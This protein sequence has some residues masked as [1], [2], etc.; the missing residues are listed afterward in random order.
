[1]KGL[2][3]AETKQDCSLASKWMEAGIGSK[4][5]AAMFAGPLFL[6]ANMVASRENV[7]TD[8]VR[9]KR[10]EWQML[11]VSAPVQIIDNMLIFELLT[12]AAYDGAS[13]AQDEFDTLATLWKQETEHLSS[14]NMIASHM[15]YQQIIGMGQDAI[16]LILRDLEE[17]Q[18]QWF[19]ALRA[20]AKESPIKPEDRGDI[21]AMTDA[22]IDWGKRHRYI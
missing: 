10:V 9:L 6:K 20:I 8:L 13:R 7:L 3:L 2:A 12:D 4:C 17:T 18:D 11:A 14:P 22:W 1:M 16:P 5:E 21:D 19:W 15:A